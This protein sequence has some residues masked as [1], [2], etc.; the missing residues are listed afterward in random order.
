MEEYILSRSKSINRR[1]AMKLAAAGAIATVTKPAFAAGR[2][3]KIGFVTPLTGPFAPL[4]VTNA[5]VVETVQKA[6]A[7]GLDIKGVN[8]P[9]QIIVKDT[10][11]TSNRASEVT[12]EL[13]L[14]DEVDIIIGG[15]HPITS[16]AIADQCELNSTPSITTMAPWQTWVFGRGGNLE[17]KYEWAH[18][19]FFGIEGFIGTFCDMW[20]QLGSNKKVGFLLPNDAMGQGA[21][22]AQQGF[23]PAMTKR[24]FEIIDVGRYENGANDYSSF[25][26]A[27]KEKKVE[28]VCGITQPPDWTNFWT[29]AAQ[30]GFKAKAGTSGASMVVPSTAEAM[31]PVLGNN[32]SCDVFWTPRFPF[33]TAIDGRT[34]EKLAEDY[35]VATGRQWIQPLGPM[36]ALF[37]AA[38]GAFKMAE[39]PTDKTS[40]S[41]AI[42]KLK[43]ETAVGMLDWTS[44]PHPN[45]A[46][47]PVMGGQWRKVEG[48]KF[49]FDLVIVSNNW[50]KDVP[51][52]G[53]MEPLSY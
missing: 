37:E 29:Q 1:N 25:I 15:I 23:P 46:L 6:L 38:I 12:T 48:K 7:K 4:A 31:G 21:A 47:T 30:Q 22:D 10:Q 17:T 28:I 52:D 39:D 40:V 9:V 41:A 3:L 35:T 45:V 5:F 51:L 27:F 34:C 49:D 19:F 18:H 26:S 11:S 36:Y 16:N 2:T 42:R 53:K 43:L 50:G 32:M 8:Y 24:G 13:I 44:G 33:K 20:D 14:N